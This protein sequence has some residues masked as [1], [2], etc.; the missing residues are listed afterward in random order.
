ML[1]CD[2]QAILIA[3]GTESKKGLA[4]TG[5]HN[6]VST[7]LGFS[8]RGEEKGGGGGAEDIIFNDKIILSRSH[9]FVLNFT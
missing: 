1:I 6:L 7:M 9:S 4:K 8:G 5:F 2:T 3:T